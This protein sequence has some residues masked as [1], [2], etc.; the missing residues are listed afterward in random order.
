MSNSRKPLKLMIS[1]RFLTS[2]REDAFYELSK[3][4]GIELLVVFGDRKG[5]QYKRFSSTAKEPRFSYK[6]LWTAS[7]VFAGFGHVNQIFFSP[8]IIWQLLRYRPS[9]VLTE[10]TS[11]ILNNLLI[12]PYCKMSGTPYVWWDLGIPRGQK[13]VNRFRKLLYPLI[14]F[15]FLRADRILG[16]SRF[17]KQYFV[18]QGYPPEKII[19]AGNTVRVEKHLERYDDCLSRK[20]DLKE[21]LGI[22]SHFVFIAVGA[23]ERAKNYHMLVKAFL[24]LQKT[25]DHIALVFVGDGADLPELKK[26][27]AGVEQ[28]IF[29]GAHYD[30]VG[31][32]FVLGD[33]Y[34][35]PG[36]GGLGINEAMAYALPVISTPADGTELELVKN[37]ETGFLAEPDSLESLLQHMSWCLENQESVREMGSNAQNLIANNYTLMHM[38]KNIRRAVEEAAN[39]EQ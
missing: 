17:A 19:P 6:K 10:G 31:D 21:E 1:Q 33:V 29:T 37:G 3:E 5:K 4:E 11:N 32:Y 16:Y 27:A 24:E 22:N 23:I 7:L 9:V 35:L 38:I 20:S 30:D 13:S 8:G 34:V 15:F 2:Y 25:H 26:Q 18:D 36:I 28:I 12:C 14:R 39:G